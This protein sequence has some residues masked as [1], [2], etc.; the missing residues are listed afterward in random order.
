[1]GFTAVQNTVCRQE[2]NK[3]DRCTHS[4]CKEFSL[5]LA[6]KDQL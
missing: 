1:M 3:R 5:Y 4:D 2:K 6:V